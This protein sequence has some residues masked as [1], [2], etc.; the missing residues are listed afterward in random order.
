MILTYSGVARE[1]SKGAVDHPKIFRSSIFG[2]MDDVNTIGVGR[3]WAH[4]PMFAVL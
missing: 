4:V 2:L 1:R 3:G